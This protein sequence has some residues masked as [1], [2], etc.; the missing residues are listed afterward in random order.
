MALIP[1]IGPGTRVLYVVL[2]LGLMAI[3]VWAPFLSRTLALIVG[4]L[5]AVSVVEGIIGF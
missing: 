3:A 2:G 5:G 4:A 1:N